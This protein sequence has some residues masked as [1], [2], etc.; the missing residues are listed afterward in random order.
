MFRPLMG[1]AIA[2]MLMHATAVQADPPYSFTN[3]GGIG[4]D[5]VTGSGQWAVITDTA[6][7]ELQIYRLNYSNMLWE[8]DQTVSSIL[9][10]TCAGGG[11]G[12]SSSLSGEAFVVGTPLYDD[13]GF[14][15]GS[16][17]TDRGAIA[18][19]SFSLGAWE[20]EGGLNCFNFFLQAMEVAPDDQAGAQFGSSVSISR[21]D[22]TNYTVVVGAPFHDGVAGADTGK[23]YVYSYNT[24]TGDLTLVDDWEGS[25]A[26]DLLGYAV[27][28]DHPYILVGAPGT[29]AG[30]VDDSQG[31]AFVYHLNG[32]GLVQTNILPVGGSDSVGREV[33]LSA[34]FAMVSSDTDAFVWENTGDASSRNYDV[35]AQTVGGIHGGDV[36]QSA[37]V[38]FYGRRLPG[39][40]GATAV[41]DPVNDD[42]TFV[43]FN[44]PAALDYAGDNVDEIGVDIRADR[45]SLFFANSAEDRA[46][47]YRYPAGFGGY[48][49]TA[50][51]YYQRSV[52]CNVV[53]QTVANVFG[54][55]GTSAGSGGVDYDIYL[56]DPSDVTDSTP[57]VQLDDNYMFTTADAAYSIWL[58]VADGGKYTPIGSCTG[59]TVPDYLLAQAG[60]TPF[61]DNIMAS[62]I[63]E[64]PDAD[65]DPNGGD[66]F[67][68]AMI[69]MPFP[70]AVRM[71]DIRYVNQ[72]GFVVTLAEADA[73]ND[74]SSTFY[75]YD[76]NST[77]PSG[78]NYRA[79]TAG[80]TPP[81]EDRIHGY[82]GFWVKVEQNGVNNGLDTH[83]L[84]MPQPE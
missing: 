60:N 67:A 8:L 64:L 50:Y 24:G 26:G 6:T 51:T 57:Y 40:V 39:L 14:C 55:L 63:I 45:E 15:D 36:S 30:G 5:S 62:V 1:I 68:R 52:P 41:R 71:A 54:Y 18:L 22:D 37:G 61:V 49:E 25:F 31:A 2:G 79:I 83:A 38:G 77:I 23:F 53:G 7:C 21:V 73:S 46:I 16:G 56:Y 82:E 4:G 27:T 42:Y 66:D 11:F 76:P 28:V 44:V 32:G 70:R 65:T 9:A 13:Q 75:V 72:S 17:A 84:Q 69:N 29:G 35:L 34:A 3:V 10:G 78:Q 20:R 33:S 58:A 12:Q 19:F 74:L 81:F 43:G 48:A 47:V 59:F 80:G